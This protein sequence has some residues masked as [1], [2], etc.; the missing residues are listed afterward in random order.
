MSDYTPTFTESTG[1]TIDVT[2]FTTEFNAIQVAIATKADTASDTLTNPT[3]TNPIGVITQGTSQDTSSG[4]SKTFESLPAGIKRIT[5]S[6]DG[7]S[8]TSAR[9]R[10]QIG[11]ATTGGY[12]TSGYTA[13]TAELKDATAVN[14]DASTA[15]FAI[16]ALATA[17]TARLRGHA[18]LVLIDAA[19][20]L[21]SFS[22]NVYDS[23]DDTITSCSGT[24][25]LAGTLDRIRLIADGV[26]AFD[27]AG[28]VNIHYMQ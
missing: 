1:D 18:D 26:E 3:L 10:I 2:D 19:T 7:L 23:G 17:G 20:W 8:V 6:F 5:M 24:V 12:I 22:A 15:G 4:T 11:D 9:I 28:Y 13:A 14:V 21:W 16:S 25:N 27:N